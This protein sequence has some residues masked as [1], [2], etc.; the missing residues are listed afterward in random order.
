MLQTQA[1]APRSADHLASQSASPESAAQQRQQQ[2][3]QRAMDA[4]DRLN[5][6]KVIFKPSVNSPSVQEAAAAELK[7]RQANQDAAP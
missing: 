2:Q 5:R 1:P 3:T 4:L 6:R 7:S